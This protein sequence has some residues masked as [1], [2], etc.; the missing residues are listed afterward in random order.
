MDSTKPIFNGYLLQETLQEN[1]EHHLLRCI[2]QAS[3][4][5]VIL[6][7]SGDESNQ[8]TNTNLINEFRLAQ[9]LKHVNIVNYLEIVELDNK[10]AIVEEDFNG[11]SLSKY[12]KT[13][14]LSTPELL[15]IALQCAQGLSFI[16]QN[17]LIHQDLHSDNI[18]ISLT[19]GTVKI[20]D[21]GNAFKANHRLLSEKEAQIVGRLEYISPEQTGKTSN[22]IDARSD[23]YSLGIV[24]YEL[25]TG[26]KPFTSHDALEI[27]HQHIAITPENPGGLN[28]NLPDIVSNLI[29]KLVSKNPED[30]Y[31]SAYGLTQDILNCI[32]IP[33]NY[34]SNS[35]FELGSHDN[36]SILRFPEKIFGR[37]KE[38]S[39]LQK[40]YRQTKFDEF[41]CAF[42]F[43]KSGIGKS[44]LVKS[45][46]SKLKESSPKDDLLFLS[47]KYQKDNESLPYLAISQLLSN[48]ITQ[49]LNSGQNLEEIRDRVTNGL[50]DNAQLLI[51]L[52][53]RFRFLINTQETIPETGIL[54]GKLRFENTLN[55]FFNIISD[56]NSPIIL[57]LDDIQWAEK[58]TLEWISALIENKAIKNCFLI[59]AYREDEIENTEDLYSLMNL[60]ENTSGLTIPLKTLDESSFDQA[61]KST[62]SADQKNIQELVNQLYTQSG[63]NPLFLRQ[64]L[65]Y[66]YE[67]NNLYFNCTSKKWQWDI[68]SLSRFGVNDNVIDIILYRINSLNTSCLE[69]LKMAACKGRQFTSEDIKLVLPEYSNDEI[70]SYL[71]IAIESQVLTK[72]ETSDFSEDNDRKS[73]SYIFQ[74]DRVHEAILGLLEKSQIQTFRYRLGKAY[75]GKFKDNLSNS[76]PSDTIF[77]L[78]EGLESINSVEEKRE[79]IDLNLQESRKLI[80][81]AAYENAYACCRAAKSLLSPDSWNEAYGLTLQVFQRYAFTSYAN[82]LLEEAENI[83]NEGILHSRTPEDSVEFYIIKIL[84]EMSNNNWEKAVDIGFKGLSHFNINFDPDA[85]ENNLET[86]IAEI[87]KS[88]K[89]QGFSSLINNKEMDN[90]IALGAMRLMNALVSPV[91]VAKPQ[92]APLLATKM[93]ELSISDGNSIAAQHAYSSYA[94]VMGT[95]LGR[96]EDSEQLAQL[97]LDLNAQYGN[98][99][100]SAKTA[101]SLIALIFPWT[102]HLSYSETLAKSYQN[103]ALQNGDLV[104]AG[105]GAALNIMY[106]FVTG[107]PLQGLIDDLQREYQFL[108]KTSN[109]VAG[110]LETLGIVFQLF[111]QKEDEE[112]SI[113]QLQEKIPDLLSRMTE[114]KFTHGIHFYHCTLMQL[115]YMIGRPDLAEPH[116]S[117]S[118]AAI[119]GAV[120]Q[121]SNVDH[122]YYKA[123]I[124]LRNDINNAAVEECHQKL[125]D[126]S[127]ICPENVLH[128]QLLVKAEQYRITGKNEEALE[129]YD[130]AISAAI[131]NHYPVDAAIAN[132]CAARFWGQRNKPHFSTIYL[133]ESYRLY[134]Q[135]GATFLTA[136]LKRSYPQLTHMDNAD[137][138]SSNSSGAKYGNQLL[139]SSSVLKAVQAISKNVEID[140]LL[141]NV[142]DII[143]ENTGARK[144]VLFIKSGNEYMVKAWKD[145]SMP[146]NTRPINIGY[147]SL[148]VKFVEDTGEHVIGSFTD[149][150]NSITTDPYL[151]TTK[152]KSYLCL[153]VHHKKQLVGILYLENDLVSN[154][155]QEHNLEPVRLILSQLGI[156]LEIASLIKEI[157]DEIKERKQAQEELNEHKIHLE[158]LIDER[159]RELRQAQEELVKNERY[160]TLGQLTSTVSHELRNPLGAIKAAIFFLEMKN[161]DGD[162]KI[163]KA[164]ERLNRNISRCDKI[165]DELLDF[166]RISNL[167]KKPLNLDSWLKDILLE[168]P[169]HEG[170]ELKIINGLGEQIVEFDPDR[171][172]R[173][174]INVFE[175]AVHAIEENT[176]A[177]GKIVVQ[178]S[179]NNGTIQISI[180]DD[181]MGMSEEVQRRI[182][183]PL[184]STR[185]FGVGLGMPTVK[186]I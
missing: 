103:I 55:R 102:R 95:L 3:N 114:S 30:R 176:T 86:A 51:D 144:G 7:M 87:D 134:K 164:Y 180:Q 27:I 98:S 57:F 116:I 159:T 60:A 155:F 158:E 182:F 119:H 33:A 111:T 56:R 156:S 108:I 65:L 5:T 38:L 149:D 169:Q 49:L 4:Y 74:H 122:N 63:G 84:L 24:F 77:L 13:N 14:I 64:A 59:C 42:I 94:F 39:L 136:R 11:I 43:A 40:Q 124:L 72:S 91:Y 99:E 172:Y 135:W 45:F 153:P 37:D 162:D 132:E 167:D 20:T 54:E 151:Q 115:Y 146:Q 148:V 137:D 23:L 106:R 61:I 53:P 121:F 110:M 130:Q 31:Q 170:I 50:G 183:E 35:V 177:Q 93:T 17:G 47:G 165:I 178:T 82:G 179:Y 173:A 90:P 58:I 32:H 150:N 140:E 18:L 101:I 44:S 107:N 81:S 147:P 100:F 109:P 152:P 1:D 83:S 22:K 10:L 15:R 41:S 36:I 171:L 120:G 73:E 105:F 131:E 154:T 133:K 185:G 68:Q 70:T 67:S 52:E 29:L 184:F 26:R 175:N 104:Y 66:M 8:N 21:F 138:S 117:L 96:Y 9:P 48:Y 75:L 12:L 141:L 34:L 161:S 92:L 69:L 16:H 62:I 186:Q 143:L 71:S 85:K 19:D 128:K 126:W 166:T 181:G 118:E 88:L 129:T 142:V 25:F 6:K 174:V 123:L 2:K 89:G 145:L 163:I 160:A 168:Q 112:T 79:L 125:K 76:I 113:E 127:N 46:I 78:N 97:S 80:A 28:T 157:S 139:N